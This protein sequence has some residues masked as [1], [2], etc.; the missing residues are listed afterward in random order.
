MGGRGDGTE[1]LF[2]WIFVINV[3]VMAIWFTR[4]RFRQ[5]LDATML[6]VAAMPL[7]VAA[8]SWASRRAKAR[9]EPLT[10]IA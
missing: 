6:V 9:R 1:R 4:I 3:P 2:I 5:P 7:A 10:E 8:A